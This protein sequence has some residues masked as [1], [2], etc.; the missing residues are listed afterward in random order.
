MFRSHEIKLNP[1]NLQEKLFKQSCGV[2]RFTFNWALNK[3]EEGYK[4]G[5]KQSAYS[6]IKQLNSIKRKEFP[7]MQE[8]GKT[9]SQYAIHNLESAYKKMWKEK[10]GYPKFKKKGKSKDSFVAVENKENFQQKDYRIRIP[11]IGWVKC[12]ENLRFE[13]KVN[14][15]VVK[16]VADMWFAVVNIEV[17][18]SIPILKQH[19]LGDNQAIVG[20]DFGIKSMMVCSDGIVFEN[21]RALK[22]NLKGLKRLQRSLTRKV[23]GSNNRKKVQIRLSRK[24]YKV[25]CVRKT[26][27]HQATAAIVKKYDKIV[28]EDLNVAGMLKNHNLSQAIGDVSFGEIRRQLTYK[29]EWYGKELVVADRFYPSSK[30]CSGCGHKK[31]TL[32]LSERIYNCES[33]GLEIDRDFNAAINLANYSP[34]LKCKGSEAC[35]EGS[36]VV[37]TQYSPSM[38]QEINDLNIACNARYLKNL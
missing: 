34:T 33:C 1:T 5:I 26:V 18:K 23:K 6:L 14:N 36:S 21:A 38:K 12:A 27:I 8:T 3:W 13:G 28:I 16:R 31:A 37:E 15:V 35:G 25:T 10:S 24:H 17:L 9:C 20:I 2:A 29:S 32:I 4:K 19:S 7:W 30:T 11:R 22:A